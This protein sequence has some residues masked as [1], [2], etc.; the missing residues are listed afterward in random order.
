M[1]ACVD[2]KRT[3]GRWE[4]RF[5]VKR[6]LQ[7]LNIRTVGGFLPQGFDLARAKVEI[8]GVSAKV[9][10]DRRITATQPVRLEQDGDG[11]SI[12]AAHL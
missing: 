9:H 10:S 8:D 3:K 11:F 12:V 6:L 5:T 4:A 1:Q 2:A 7:P